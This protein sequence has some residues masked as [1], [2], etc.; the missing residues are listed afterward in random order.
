MLEISLRIKLLTK[1]NLKM[2]MCPNKYFKTISNKIIKIFKIA[3]EIKK[4]IRIILA[5]IIL[6][7]MAM[8]KKQGNFRSLKETSR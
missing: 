5:V 4:C 8:K 1:A 3:T 7:A 2:E 6:L